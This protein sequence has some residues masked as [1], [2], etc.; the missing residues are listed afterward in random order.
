MRRGTASSIFWTRMLH[1][2]R[3]SIYAKLRAGRKRQ[4]AHPNLRPLPPKIPKVLHSACSNSGIILDSRILLQERS[5]VQIT[6][7]PVV[8]TDDTLQTHSQPTDHE[9]LR[10]PD[11]NT[12]AV[13]VPIAST[14]SRSP[15]L[16]TPGKA[17]S[18]ILRRCRCV[19]Q[20]T[21]AGTQVPKQ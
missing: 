10:L 16:L 20:I 1:S 7:I 11:S 9:Y 15:C 13:L 21:P 19:V 5:P 18:S 8:R 2:F 17:P 4:R 6:T 3:K 14:G 12:E